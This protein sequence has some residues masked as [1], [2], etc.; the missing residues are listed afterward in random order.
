MTLTLLLSPLQIQYYP[1]KKI[2][3]NVHIGH[4]FANIFQP[5]ICK[6]KIH[7]APKKVW[8]FQTSPGDLCFISQRFKPSVFPMNNLSP[9]FLLS[10]SKCR[11]LSFLVF[12]LQIMRSEVSL[13]G[14]LHITWALPKAYLSST[15]PALLKW[16]YPSQSIYQI[17]IAH[18]SQDSVCHLPDYPF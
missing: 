2:M 11:I 5:L 8:S 9:S 6:W 10:P 18:L 7:T 4:K 15:C 17:C 16:N 3:Q 13:T 12:S 14:L 1:H